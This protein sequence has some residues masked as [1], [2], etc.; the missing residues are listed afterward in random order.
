MIILT[1]ANE[2]KRLAV[3][4]FASRHR[5]GEQVRVLSCPSLVAHTPAD[6]E[7]AI[8]GCLNRIRYAAGQ[9]D[10][11]P[12]GSLYVALEGLVSTNRFGAFVCGWA[13]IATTDLSRYLY[14]CSTKVKL[15]EELASLLRQ[16]DSLG[17]VMSRA[18]PH[19]PQP[20]RERLGANG[21]VTGGAF[22]RVHEFNGALECA[23][24]VQR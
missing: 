22:T 1:S 9:M 10:R 5:P 24:A 15:P 4:G 18:Y 6:D 16:G 21:L 20:E 19:V 11:V 23:W 14:G 2:A 7:E 8:Q 13:V 12:D 3:E 17:E